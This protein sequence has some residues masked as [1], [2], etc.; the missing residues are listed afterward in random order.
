MLNSNT[1]SS[2]IL[3][4]AFDGSL[5][6]CMHQLESIEMLAAGTGNGSLRW[7]DMFRSRLCFN[8]KVRKCSKAVQALIFSYTIQVHWYFPGSNASS[9][10]GWFCW[11][12]FPFSYFCIML[13]WVWHH[14]SL[15]NSCF[16]VLDC[17]RSKY[18]SL[19]VIWL[20]E[21][22]CYYLMASSWRICD[23]GMLNLPKKKKKPMLFRIRVSLTLLHPITSAICQCT[24]Q[25]HYCIQL[26][27]PEDHLLISSSHD[28]TL[29]IWDLR[30]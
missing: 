2:G 29:R 27:A 4:S 22:K 8:L 5:Y 15:W 25:K 12:W 6:T 17:C 3:T 10:E 1:L 30:R 19:S 26:A 18:W 9:V 21:W 13:L 7:I 28:R 24:Y 14:T 16:T 20:E 11:I 23:K